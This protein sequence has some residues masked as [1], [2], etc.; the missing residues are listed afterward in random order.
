MKNFG[1]LEVE[2]KWNTI[3]EIEVFKKTL[4]KIGFIVIEKEEEEYTYFLILRED[5]EK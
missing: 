1:K 2:G 4:K 5:D 3:G